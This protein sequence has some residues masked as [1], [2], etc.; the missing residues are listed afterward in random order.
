MSYQSAFDFPRIFVAIIT[1]HFFSSNNRP[2]KNEIYYSNIIS[3]YDY[4]IKQTTHTHLRFSK[5][6]LYTYTNSLLLNK[7]W[8]LERVRYEMMQFTSVTPSIR[9]RNSIK[10]MILQ[11]YLYG[12][13]HWWKINVWYHSSLIKLT[14]NNTTIEQKWRENIP[15]RLYIYYSNGILM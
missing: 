3:Y 9:Y 4:I 5:F 11:Y 7:V 10:H 13:K 12:T 1:F 2:V 6:I 15:M 14:V 8:A